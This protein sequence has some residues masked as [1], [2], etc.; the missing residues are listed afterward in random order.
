MKADPVVDDL[1]C[2]EPVSDFVQIDG[3]LFQGS[4]EAFDEDVVQIPSA[5]IH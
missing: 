1:F 5:P 4:P 3:L 2:L